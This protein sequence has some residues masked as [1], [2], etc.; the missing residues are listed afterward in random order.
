MGDDGW[1]SG[2]NVRDEGV[3]FQMDVTAKPSDGDGW[4]ED[5]AQPN[6]WWALK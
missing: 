2:G 6:L 5:S 4:M 1:L 3:E